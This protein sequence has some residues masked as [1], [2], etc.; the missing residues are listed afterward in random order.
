[1][2]RLKN[3]CNEFISGDYFH[4]SFQLSLLASHLTSSQYQHD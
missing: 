4:D 1:M 2:L 3:Q